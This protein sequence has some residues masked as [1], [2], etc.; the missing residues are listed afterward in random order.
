MN[1]CKDVHLLRCQLITDIMMVLTHWRGI[2]GSVMHLVSAGSPH[3]SISQSAPVTAQSTANANTATSSTLSINRVPYSAPTQGLA[4][5]KLSTLC[6]GIYVYVN[7]NLFFT[8]DFR[9]FH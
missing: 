7:K 6:F 8:Y 3:L 9:F 5:L 4:L 1:L 2:T